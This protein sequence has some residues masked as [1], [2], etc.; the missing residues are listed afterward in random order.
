MMKHGT[1]SLMRGIGAGRKKVIAVSRSWRTDGLTDWVEVEGGE[2]GLRRRLRRPRGWKK[3][4]ACGG[5]G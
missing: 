1:A 2:E 3:R 5:L 4:R